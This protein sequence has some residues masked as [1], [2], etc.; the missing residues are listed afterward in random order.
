[1]DNITR[2]V[3]VREFFDSNANGAQV[4]RIIIPKI[5]RDYAQGR[6]DKGYIREEFLKEIYSVIKS[7]EYSE[8]SMDFI[9]GYMDEDNKVFY[10]LDG[11]QRLTTLWL[12]YWYLAVRAEKLETEENNLKLFSYDTRISSRDFCA[13]LCNGN[14]FCAELYNDDDFKK[15]INEDIVQFIKDQHWFFSEWQNDPTI[16]AM[17]RTIGGEG[18]NDG[19]QPV[20]ADHTKRRY[21]ETWENFLERFKDRITFYEYIIGNKPLPKEAAAQLYIKMNARGKAL[22]DFENFRADLIDQLSKL[23]KSKKRK[24]DEVVSFSEN[25]DYS[26]SGIFLNDLNAYIKNL[27]NS[28]ADSAEQKENDKDA[29]KNLLDVLGRNTDELFFSWI[30]R[31]CYGRLCVAEREAADTDAKKKGAEKKGVVKKEPLLKTEL[32]KLA[33]AI[34]DPEKRKQ[35][36]AS[37]RAKIEALYDGDHEESLRAINQ[38]IYLVSD[39]TSYE[40]YDVYEGLLPYD[41][42][43]NSF[44]SLCNVL[45]GLCTPIDPLNPSGKTKTWA[46]YIQESL[47]GT[48]NPCLK[49]RTPDA[50]GYRFLPVYRR[51]TVGKDGKLLGN[52]R[53]KKNKGGSTVGQ[54]R[55]LQLK[56]RIYFSVIC[57]FLDKNYNRLDPEKFIDWLY[58]CRNV[59][60]NARINSVTTMIS[61]LRQLEKYSDHSGDILNYLYTLKE[62]TEKWG[63]V[64]FGGF[65]YRKLSYQDAQIAEEIQK[66]YMIQTGAISKEQIREVE[67]YSVF[68]GCIRFLFL[69][70]SAL[71]DW[72]ETACDTFETRLEN[73]KK[74]FEETKNAVAYDWV[75]EFAEQYTDFDEA[76][77]KEIYHTRG[78]AERGDSWLGIVC[79]TAFRKESDA[80][81]LNSIEKNADGRYRAFIDSELFDALVKKKGLMEE[82]SDFRIKRKGE[83]WACVKKNSQNDMLI[84]DDDGFKRNEQIKQLIKTGCYYTVNSKE[85]YEE[86]KSIEIGDYYWYKDVFV[87]N[88]NDKKVYRFD[89]DGRIHRIVS[90]NTSKECKYED[91]VPD[92]FICAKNAT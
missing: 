85:P 15:K 14:N 51:R 40:K 35:L 38:Y 54:V 39:D 69:N 47:N 8:L 62:H 43:K 70:D 65:E 16:S 20:F 17:L 24:T 50:S 79:D 75:K 37:Q 91:L 90:G 23:K 82:K 1:M 80:W 25:I 12:V 28:S 52:I 59:I 67:D 88:K 45:N 22:S 78:W 13:E 89:S 57:S 83:R 31:F 19:I 56:D 42:E 64:G 55:G 3:S 49:K 11:Q 48:V 32:I 73:A 9:Y 30:N 84:F 36:K 58:F 63:E 26:W 81:L 29:A 33:D 2:K 6:E 18:E 71:E 61:C 4:R 86:N 77:E 76:S 7:E 41:R 66:A 44:D 92:P 34:E 74:I 21:K 60:E 87:R 27:E 72:G 5:Q 10:P 46:D 53:T 68:C